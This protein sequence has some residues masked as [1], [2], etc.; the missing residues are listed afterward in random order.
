[1]GF[2]RKDE[3]RYYRQGR[4]PDGKPKFVAV[5]TEGRQLGDK[6]CDIVATLTEYADS[7]LVSGSC[8]PQ[9]CT[10]FIG[11]KQRKRVAF[12][13]MPKSWQQRFREVF[14]KEATARGAFRLKRK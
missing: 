14:G 5:V 13:E 1:M 3:I 11:G 6:C 8:V 10:G 2:P 7:A 12:D 9:F 4:D